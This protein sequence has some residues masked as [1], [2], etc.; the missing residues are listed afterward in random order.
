MALNDA[1]IS[2]IIKDVRNEDERFSY[3]LYGVITN[4]TSNAFYIFNFSD[5]KI[6]LI[7]IVGINTIVDYSII[8]IDS[9][10]SIKFSNWFLG[11]GRK[12][13]IISKEEHKVILK[14]NKFNLGMK[15]QKEH[16]IKIEKEYKEMGLVI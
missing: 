3:Y 14:V 11:I 2:E 12:I 5:K 15:K 6:D 7:E 16:L 9:I 10:K 13:K 4:G 1:I 8:P